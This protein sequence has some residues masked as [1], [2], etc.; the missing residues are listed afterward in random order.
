MSH[1]ALSRRLVQDKEACRMW[2]AD[3]EFS[4]LKPSPSCC[5]P[6]GYGACAN[7]SMLVQRNSTCGEMWKVRTNL[8]RV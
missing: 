2:W 6:P 5:A 1:V 3:G 4:I 8:I 7:G